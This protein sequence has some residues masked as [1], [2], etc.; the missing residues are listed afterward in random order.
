[1]PGTARAI[2][3]RTGQ[4]KGLNQ[5][6]ITCAPMARATDSPSP[7]AAPLVAHPL[8]EDG[9]NL[10]GISGGHGCYSPGLMPRVV[11]QRAA[12]SSSVATTSSSMSRVVVSPSSAAR[13]MWPL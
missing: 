4:G 11:S 13:R 3:W 5:A 2:P 12:W 10:L 1:M 6:T 8:V 7:V 9:N